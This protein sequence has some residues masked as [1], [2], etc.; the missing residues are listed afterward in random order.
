MYAVILF[1]VTGFI[2]TVLALRLMALDA[3][4]I[5]TRLTVRGRVVVGLLVGLMIAAFVV[6]INGVWWNCDL[7]DASSVCEVRWGY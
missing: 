1:I 6:F 7:T 5:P 3:E 4:V 2:G